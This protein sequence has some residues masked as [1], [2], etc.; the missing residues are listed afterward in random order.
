MVMLPNGG[1]LLMSLAPYQ[2][3]Q[4]VP[5]PA[6][7]ESGAPALQEPAILRQDLNTVNL[8][9]Q[10]EMV[11]RRPTAR[12][13][14]T[15][16]STA[17]PTTPSPATFTYPAAWKNKIP[18]FPYVPMPEQEKEVEDLVPVSTS[19]PLTTPSPFTR[20]LWETTFQ[21]PTYTTLRQAS[22]TTKSP[23][24]NNHIE[25]HHPLLKQEQG[26][27][28]APSSFLLPVGASSSSPPKKK[29][30]RQEQQTTLGFDNVNVVIP[31]RF[32]LTPRPD[33]VTQCKRDSSTNGTRVCTTRLA[34]NCQG[35]FKLGGNCNGQQVGNL[36]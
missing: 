3:T 36:P 24:F 18:K 20:P 21:P 8:Q 11:M 2:D 35:G 4:G 1:L 13:K 27:V 5:R 12:L 34:N 32:N 6:P 23:L 7:L 33:G 26:A 31:G 30:Y 29:R 16:T 15:S 19:L 17:K 10:Q 22:T 25:V 28:H 9:Q 14:T